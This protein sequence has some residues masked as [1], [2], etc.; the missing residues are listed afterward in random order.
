MKQSKLPR[1][2][3]APSL[4]TSAYTWTTASAPT[5]NIPVPRRPG[6]C[7]SSS[8]KDPAEAFNECLNA[9]HPR[10]KFTR[11]EESDGSLAFLNV[12]I[13]QLDNGRLSTKVYRKPSNTKLSS[14]RTLARTQRSILPPSKMSC[15]ALIASAP[16]QQPQKKKL[17]GFWTFLKT[18]ATAVK[19]SSNLLVSPNLHLQHNW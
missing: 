12:F 13:T 2:V 3:A 5:K 14:S 8:F 19:T 16:H 10:L 15:V 11:E 17:I 7:S 9:V 6:L 4:E 1:S 18:M